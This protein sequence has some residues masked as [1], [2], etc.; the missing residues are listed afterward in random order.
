M[1]NIIPQY[2]WEIYWMTFTTMG[3]LLVLPIAIHADYIDWKLLLEFTICLIFIP[4]GRR[5]V[6]ILNHAEKYI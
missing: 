6:Y 5:I 2:R 1:N 4:L 3:M